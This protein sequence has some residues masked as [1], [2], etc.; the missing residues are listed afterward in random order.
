MKNQFLMKKFILSSVALLCGIMLF[1]Q[2]KVSTR[3]YI[4]SDFTDKITKVVL[5]GNGIMESALRQEVTDRWAASPFEFCSLEEFE[6]LKTSAD[7]YFLIP[8]EGKFKGEESPGIVFLTLVKGGAEKEG[9]DPMTEIISLPLSSVGAGS[10]RMLVYLSSLV[11]AIQSYTL[12]AMQSE[13]TAYLGYAFFNDNYARKGHFKRIYMPQGDLS[14]KVSE[15]DKEKYIDE[16]D[17]IL[18]DEDEADEIFDK[19]TF[20]TLVSFVV[21]PENPT[22]GSYSYQMLIESD[23]HVIYYIRKHKISDKSPAGFAVDDLKRL[24]RRR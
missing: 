1:A 7:Y 11:E 5:P 2:G 14:T 9:I 16:D 22:E 3:K 18:C 15:K 17:F 12:A 4:L 21:A 10:G 6:K 13:K 20:G 24:S 23:T 19:G 8:A